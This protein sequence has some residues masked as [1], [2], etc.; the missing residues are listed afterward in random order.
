MSFRNRPV[1]DRKHRPRWQDEL[2]TQRLI[3]GGF[4]VAIAAAIGIFGA[5]AWFDYYNNHL[6]PVAAVGKATYN[7]DDLGRRMDII[8]SELQARYVELNDQLG[9]V[10]DPVIQQAQQSIQTALQSLVST[11]SDSMVLTSALT[12]LAGKYGISVSDAQVSAEVIRRQTLVERLKMSLISIRALPSDAA[13]GAKPTDSDWANALSKI[14]DLADQIRG[15]ADF[16]SLAKDNSADPSASSGGSLG[17]AQADDSVYATYFKEAHA[18]A[19]GQLI[20][21]IKDDN[22]YHLLRLD[23][24]REAAPDTVL[25]SLLSSAGVSEAD[26]RTY[27]YGA[28]LKTAFNDY[29]TTKVET[30]YQPQKEVAQ[31][32]IISS[33]G[34]PVPQQHLRHFLAQPLPGATDQSTATDAEWAAALARAEAFRAEA[35]KPNADWFTLAK[36]SDDTGSAS[37]GGDLGW[38]DPASSSFADDFKA[39]VGKLQ[40]GQLSEPV[41]TQFGYHVIEITATRTSPADQAQSLVK[42]LRANPDQFAETARA[43]SQD[44]TSAK[45]GGDLGWVIH[46]Q[47]DKARDDAIFSLTTPGQISDAIETS[48]GFYIFKLIDSS[49]ARWVPLEQLSQVRQAGF[50]GW[51]TQVRDSAGV[52]VDPQYAAATA[53]G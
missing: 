11:A 33:Q 6:A 46:Y 52:W 32:Y 2:R 10:R 50:A 51:L 40:V 14:N 26:Y 12:D 53:T 42:A 16:A 48:G 34:V 20:G 39:A 37:Q 7:L 5:T 19:I 28:L 4:A 18:A 13:T 15:G 41:K 45:V 25:K 38:Y 22:G 24:R 23:G 31:I 8:G 21:P 27:V 9:G 1:L 43:Q 3:V 49:P 47:F 44:P 17:W 29:F 35:V 36:S 30:A